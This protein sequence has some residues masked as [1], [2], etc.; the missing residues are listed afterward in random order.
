M[1]K[2]HEIAPR[3]AIVIGR[4]TPT[5]RDR[6]RRLLVHEARGDES[7]T[8]LAVAAERM[9][10]RLSRHSGKVLG[11]DTFYALLGRAL[12]LVK[13]DFP[14]LETVTVEPSQACLIG[15]R[16]SLEGQAVGQVSDG[17]VAVVATFLA[18]LATLIGE[19]LSLS[20]LVEVWAECSL[21]DVSITGEAEK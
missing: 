21:A 18:L 19:E 2:P 8:G 12:A 13:A 15:L 14:F 10:K 5:Q 6:A 9:C 20:V 11:V 4:P 7:S 17:I 16:E 1:R 3:K